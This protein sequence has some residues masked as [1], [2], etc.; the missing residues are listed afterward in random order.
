MAVSVRVTS[1]GEEHLTGARRPNVLISTRATSIDLLV[2]NEETAPVIRRY[3]V[4]S[5]S[6]LSSLEDP[7]ERDQEPRQ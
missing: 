4:E 3:D 7:R 6:P 2:M 5:G 1:R